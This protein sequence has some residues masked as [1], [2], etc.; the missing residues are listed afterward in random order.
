MKFRNDKW[1]DGRDGL[2][3]ECESKNGKID[4][5]Q[6]YPTVTFRFVSLSQGILVSG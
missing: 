4:N 3:N 5:G 2:K 6:D 1:K